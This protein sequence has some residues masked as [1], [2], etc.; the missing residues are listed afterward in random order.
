MNGTQRTDEEVEEAN[1]H[2][3][4]R[5]DSF[6][7]AKPSGTEANRKIRQTPFHFEDKEKVRVTHHQVNATHVS[8]FAAEVNLISGGTAMKR[9][10]F[11]KK[12][13]QRL[14]ARRDALRRTIAGE[15]QSLYT[16]ESGVVDELDTSLADANAEIGSQMVEVES[17]ELMQIDRAIEKMRAGRYG[18][19]DSCGGPIKLIR[20]QA[21]PYAIE[22][23]ECARR[24]E[25]R[26]SGLGYRRGGRFDF[27]DNASDS[28]E[29]ISI[30]DAE[31]EM[32]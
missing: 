23:I 9:N 32:S 1:R 21:V 30:D 11:I 18:L 29:N 4:I 6:A 13:Q 7:R 10:E 31:V 17:R 24:D 20:L 15:V 27:P 14:I 26:E 28:G 5:S 16:S 12:M 19:C 25:R 22:C 3:F 2:F 8:R